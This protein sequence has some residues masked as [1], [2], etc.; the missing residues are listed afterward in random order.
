METGIFDIPAPLLTWVDLALA[1]LLPDSVRLVFW[2]I[3]AGVASMG[4]YWLTSPQEKLRQA[5]HDAVAARQ[6]LAAYDGEFE[7]IWPVMGRSLS[8]SFRHLGL[9]LGP[10]L[11]GSLPVLVLMG[12]MAGNYGY[13]LP[14][15]GRQVRMQAQPAGITL[16]WSEDG[17]RVNSSDAWTATWPTPDAPRSLVDAFGNT[18]VTIPLA[19]PVPV[20]HKRAWWNLFFANPLGSLPETAPVDLIG[21]ELPVKTFLPFG[22]GWMQGWEASFI[23]VVLVASI[24]VKFL[25]RIR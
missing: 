19:Q 9:A 16:A 14:D 10:A 20:I 24:A 18:L 11:L 22:P 1:A 3:A 23:L 13:E 5:K 12:W 15:A 17:A 4:L 25:F 21:I 2:G 7:G 8:T 6:A